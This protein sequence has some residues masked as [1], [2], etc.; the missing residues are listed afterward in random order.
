MNDKLIKLAERWEREAKVAL[1]NSE[2][3]ANIRPNEVEM[4]RTAH[5]YLLH[6][7]GQLRDAIG[8]PRVLDEQA[9]RQRAH[10]LLYPTKGRNDG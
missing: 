8:A 4:C 1:G 6:C 7:A 3:L 10:A 9:E 2:A 5:G